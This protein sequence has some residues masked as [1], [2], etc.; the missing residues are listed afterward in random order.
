MKTVFYEVGAEAKEADKHR[1]SR[2]RLP[3]PTLF[4]RRPTSDHSSHILD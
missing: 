4:T 1:V 2:E 3:L